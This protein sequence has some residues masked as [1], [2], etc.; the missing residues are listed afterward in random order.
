MKVEFRQVKAEGSEFDFSV[1][2]LDLDLEVD[3]FKFPEPI[4]IQLIATRSGDE[5]ICQGQ[6]STAIEAECSRCLEL[7]EKQINSDLQFVIQFLDVGGPE[8]SGDDDFIVLPKTAEDYSIDDR[9][10]EAIIMELPIKPLCEANCKGLCSMCGGDLN[11]T[12]CG[13]TQDKTDERWDNLKQLFE[14]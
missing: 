13:C 11:E 5:I 3:G 8:D 9:V 10:R 12:D 6:V 7:F 14:E 4:E 1:K 2:A